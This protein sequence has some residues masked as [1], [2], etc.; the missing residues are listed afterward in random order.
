M[1]RIHPSERDDPTPRALAQ[2]ER[3]DGQAE[4]TDT[5]HKV[6]LDPGMHR[7][8]D[9]GTFDYLTQISMGSD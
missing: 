3:G 2:A 6:D 4:R 8:C 5:E 9:S 7:L 1:T